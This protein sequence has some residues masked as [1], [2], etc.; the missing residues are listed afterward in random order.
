M[1]IPI[2]RVGDM[3]LLGLMRNEFDSTSHDRDIDQFGFG[4]LRREPITFPLF[5]DVNEATHNHVDGLYQAIISPLLEGFT[6]T[7]PDGFKVLFSGRV[8]NITP[9]APVDGIQ[10]A[11]VT[12]RASGPMK[13]GLSGAM[14]DVGVAAVPL[15]EIE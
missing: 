4:V 12:I 8:R 5:F 3:T 2:A 13:M 10:T 15:S 11:N 7:Q 9:T 1:F 6:V 14:I